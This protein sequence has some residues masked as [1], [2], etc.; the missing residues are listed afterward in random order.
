MKNKIIIIL[1]L[2]TFFCFGGTDKKRIDKYSKK[3]INEFLNDKSLRNLII[4]KRMEFYSELFIGLK[5]YL[6]SVG[7]GENSYYDTNPLVNFNKTN[8]M[9]YCEHVIDLS[10][11]DSWENFFNNLQYIRYKKGIISIVTRNHYIMADW[12]LNNSW[13]FYD[14]TLKVSPEGYEKTTRTISHKDFFKSKK[15]YDLQNIIDDRTITINYIPKD[16]INKVCGNFQSG[17][18]FAIVLSNKKNIFIGHLIMYFEI[19]KNKVIRDASSGKKQVVEVS[20]QSWLET[21]ISQL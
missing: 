13:L 12:I 10:I 17:D 3:E 20:F 21:L 7:D 16:N 14:A 5:Y 18:I 6:K 9:A 4:T 8:C 2:L 11:S 1:L 19:N 15:I